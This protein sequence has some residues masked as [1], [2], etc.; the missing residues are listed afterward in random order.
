MKLDK[1]DRRLMTWACLLFLAMMVAL[2]IL[3]SNEEADSGV[4]STYSAQSS[5]AKAS[6]LLLGE[7][8]YKV[9]RWEQSPEALP[10][11]PSQTILVMASPL[12]APSSDERLT[13][14]RFLNRGGKILITGSR[15]GSYLPHVE[16]EAE[17][18]PEPIPKLYQPQTI[19]SL[20]RGG[21]IRMSPTAYW[22]RQGAGVL[23]HYADQ[24]RPIVISHKSGK[25]EIIWWG[26]STPLSNA[27]VNSAGNLE[28]LLN[29]L[30][31][32]GEARVLWDEYFHGS[33]SSVGSYV[34]TAP[35]L[36]GLAQGGLIVLVMILTYSRRNGP[37]Y[38]ASSASRL[39]PL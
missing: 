3:S 12:V 1:S 18:V 33:R 34:A 31:A 16:T 28:L 14:E 17:P 22:Q 37:I 2:A 15:A 26:A 10:A 9:E 25:G 39:S 4:P 36:W 20:T 6:Y 7:L 23:V 38:P 24:D 27:H 5:G 29:S 35:V 8:G 11:D 30:G 32:P 19:S 21:S 13:L